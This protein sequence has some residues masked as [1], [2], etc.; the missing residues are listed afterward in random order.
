MSAL[1]LGLVAAFAWGL[2]DLCVR[3]VSQRT[4][5]LSALATVLAVGAALVLPVAV[6][7]GDWR[8]M[9]AAAY[10]LA[11][12]SGVFF[13]LAGFG[14]YKAFEI[15]PVRLVAPVVG[16]YPVLTMALAGLGGAPVTGG[17]W[18]A[19]LAVVMG[20]GIVA[21]L[22]REGESNGSRGTAIIWAI[23]SAIGFAG[24]FAVGQYAARAGADLPVL[25]STRAAAL[26]LVLPLAMIGRAGARG[27]VRQ[28]P[29]LV[30]MGV[31]DAVALGAIMVAAPLPNPEFAAVA[32]ATFGVITIVLASILFKER[33]RGGQW[34]GVA[35]TFA[36]IGYLAL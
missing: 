22:I 20:I 32:A 5:I 15:G 33:M 4:S 14:L 35:L 10:G 7:L 2:H 34:I 30:A 25:M 12:L 31:L 6:W 9:T 26:V 23:L 16:A 11:V 21:A 1:G 18:M 19:A 3:H 27:I 13:G 8:A 36:G 17:Q 28:L 24:T 29:L